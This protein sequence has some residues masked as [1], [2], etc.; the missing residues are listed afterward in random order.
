M[1]NKF[2]KTGLFL[3]SESLLLFAI[4]SCER[5][6]TGFDGNES[7][8]YYTGKQAEPPPQPDSTVSV[9]TWNMRFAIGR[10]E[11]FGDACGTKV[12]YTEDEILLKLQSL[13]DRIN[14]VKPDILLL[15]EVDINSKRSV[16]V[17]QLR[18][19]LDHTYFGYAVYGYQW[20]AQ[21]IPSDG[22]GRLQEAN[23]ILS[24]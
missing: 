17:D 2:I 6:A 20:K 15:Q 24:R 3:I 10:G 22:L 12:I 7:A 8:I 9:M 11:W 13:A 1:K 14:Q 19:I 23:A 16:Y 5:P 4:F 21:F 18:W